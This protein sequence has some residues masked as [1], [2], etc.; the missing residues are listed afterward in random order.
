MIY[1][2]MD[3]LRVQMGVVTLVDGTAEFAPRLAKCQV[4][5]TPLGTAEAVMVDEVPGSDD[6]LSVAPGG[7]VTITSSNASSTIQVFCIAIGPS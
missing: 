3:G 6:L 1:G 2:K 5:V 7:T 4:Y